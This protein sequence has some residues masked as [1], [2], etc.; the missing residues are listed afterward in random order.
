MDDVDEE[1]KDNES[2]T[3]ESR[4][5]KRVGQRRRE[6]AFYANRPREEA[7]M[8]SKQ[9]NRPREEDEE[10]SMQENLMSIKYQGDIFGHYISSD[11]GEM[12]QETAGQFTESHEIRR[13][14]KHFQ[15]KKHIFEMGK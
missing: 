13:E 12:K 7:E 6:D 2:D 8:F 11:V 3:G 15:T 5:E 9:E 1:D 14:K 10:L 4:Q